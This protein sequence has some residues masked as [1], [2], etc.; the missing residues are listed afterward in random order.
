MG[1]GG[2]EYKAG[3]EMESGRV[4]VR[5]LLFL[6]FNHRTSLGLF[7]SAYDGLAVSVKEIMFGSKKVG[8]SPL[9]PPPTPSFYVLIS[10]F[11]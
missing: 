5:G 4:G 1:V 8:F 6:I 11:K 3:R 2:W 9:L 10:H 7:Q